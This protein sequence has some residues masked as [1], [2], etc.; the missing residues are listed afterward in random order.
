MQW[1]NLLSQE[2]FGGSEDMPYDETRY[3]IGEFEKDYSKI[4]NS[5]AFRRL[6][7]KTQV[8]PLDKSDFVRTRLTHSIEV[9][10]LAKRIGSMALA[11]IAAYQ[12]ASGY[13]LTAEESAAVLE[14]LTCAGLLHDLGN[15]PF[16]HFGEV[17]IGDWFSQHLRSDA[18]T[19]KGTPVRL[20]LSEPM[21]KD[22]CHFEG[23]AQTLR[24]LT[25]L[26]PASHPCGMNLTAAVL[27]TLLKY[28]TDCLSF[29]SHASDIKLH[30]L[31]YYFA[32]APLV[33]ALGESAGT[34][35]P[36]GFC[37]HPL[38]Y[39]LEAA[40]DIAYATADLEDAHKK[41]MFSLQE[42]VRFYRGRLE[43]Y[44]SQMS[45]KQ[46]EKSQALIDEL[47]RQ[48]DLCPSEQTA[49]QNWVDYARHWLA[50]SA[51]F[52][53]TSQENYGLI[54]TGAYP[55]DI[56]HNTFHEYSIR[57]MKQDAPQE[58]V[59]HS[60][61]IVKLELAAQSIITSLLDKFVPAVLYL[62]EQDDSFRQ[63]KGDKK[64][65][66]LISDN[67]MRSYFDH[68][69]QDESFNLYLRLLLV[70]DYLSGMTD[71]YAKDLYQSLQGVY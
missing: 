62:D 29:D 27:H 34:L 65:T 51:A 41:S 63:T 64:L 14:I 59:F 10:S 5:A 53:F 9:S 7:D 6:Q 8:F 56:L 28:P 38:T 52:G 25:K 31:G 37:R 44:R 32:E 68:K 30:K 47:E 26:H 13:T 43:V 12:S 54:M 35:G 50:Y 40:D 22:L 36:E 39:L 21:R 17:V 71:S 49:F 18:F 16:G 2:R 69:T 61:S 60:A 23:N 11:N 46:L 24:I 55:H 15:P 66:S 1:S 70:T 20:L 67:Y 58:F 57:I 42:F 45:E 48:R 33:H 3:P 19:Y 4:I